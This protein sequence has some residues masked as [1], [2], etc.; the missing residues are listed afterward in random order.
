[1]A[2][3]RNVQIFTDHALKAPKEDEAQFVDR[4]GSWQIH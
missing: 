4:K 2:I 3:T 1:M